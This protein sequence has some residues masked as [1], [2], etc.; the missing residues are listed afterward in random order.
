LS[1]GVC[2]ERIS[3]GRQL[4]GFACRER[5]P[6]EGH[7]LLYI[8]LVP[9][10]ARWA[11][12]DPFGPSIPPIELKPYSTCRSPR[13]NGIGSAVPSAGEDRT[14]R[15]RARTPSVAVGASSHALCKG[16]ILSRNYDS[17][18]QRNSIHR[19]PGMDAVLLGALSES[20]RGR[21]MTNPGI[22]LLFDRLRCKGYPADAPIFAGA[23]RISFQLAQ[24]LASRGY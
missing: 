5:M 22:L 18:E 17:M 20:D 16:H 2:T 3:F 6:E 13:C 15:S 12:A 23:Q 8:E 7:A 14:R 9:R 1:H 21:G 19:V 10:V 11:E 24:H 4:F